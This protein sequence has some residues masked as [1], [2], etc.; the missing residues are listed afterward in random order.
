MKQTTHYF[1]RVMWTRRREWKQSGEPPPW[2]PGY[3]LLKVFL[4][5]PTRCESTSWP[6]VFGLPI[7]IIKGAPATH[8]SLH[9]V[10]KGG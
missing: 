3:P 8:E 7:G 6:G 4:V 10:L 5:F 2:F 9:S 1:Q